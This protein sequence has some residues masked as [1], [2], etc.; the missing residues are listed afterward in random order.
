MSDAFDL[1]ARISAPS[2]SPAGEQAPPPS[3]SQIATRTVCTKSV[4]QVT[5]TC[6]GTS[7]C[8]V[9]CSPGK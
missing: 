6:A 1:D 3:I 5:N 8:T 9:F 2:A 4:C 7:V